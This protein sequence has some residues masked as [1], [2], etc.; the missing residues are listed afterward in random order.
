MSF[1]PEC[2]KMN[3]TFKMLKNKIVKLFV[4]SK[5]FNKGEKPHIVIIE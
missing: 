3:F 4:K 1:H 5:L 2:I